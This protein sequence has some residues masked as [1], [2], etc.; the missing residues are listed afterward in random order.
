M[1]T[2]IF[3]YYILY[4]VALNHPT[5]YKLKITYIQSIFVA[6]ETIS[7]LFVVAVCHKSVKYVGLSKTKLSKIDIAHS[8]CGI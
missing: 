7:S 2:F 5:D 1:F 6:T 8:T 3:C 4:Y